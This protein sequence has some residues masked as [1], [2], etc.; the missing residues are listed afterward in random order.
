MIIQFGLGS[1]I[2]KKYDT[3]LGAPAMFSLQVRMQ[4]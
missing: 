3:A 4:V 2:E 1:T